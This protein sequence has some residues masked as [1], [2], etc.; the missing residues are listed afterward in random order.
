MK[1]QTYPIPEGC[2]AI[3]MEIIDNAIVTT[4]EPEKVEFKKGDFVKF[5]NSGNIIILSKDVCDKKSEQGCFH[6]KSSFI[7]IRKDGNLDW[8]GGTDPI[9]AVTNEEKQ[10]AIDALAK[11]N[12]MWDAEKMEIVELKYIPK[13]GD[14]V[15]YENKFKDV[16]FGEIKVKDHEYNSVTSF[17]GIGKNYFFKNDIWFLNVN[18][19]SETKITPEDLQSEFN[20][21]GYEYDF[22]THEAKKLR[23]KPTLNSEYWCVDNVGENVIITEWDNDKIDN[24]RYSVGNC[25]KTEA[26][27]QNFKEYILA[28]EPEKNN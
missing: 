7:K 22:E 24:K 5:I 8:T 9:I 21:L 6:Y 27:A 25:F 1:K 10:F 28:Y 15:K 26:E 4:F 19:C 17:I 13:V 12:K 20:K 16:F 2:K 3:S 18:D 14:C 23:W 11:E